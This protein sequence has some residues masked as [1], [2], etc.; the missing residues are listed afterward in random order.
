MDLHSVRA[1]V[2]V[3]REG[4]FTRAARKLDRT[5]PT[6]TAAVKKLESALGVELL[7]RSGRSVKVTRA[8]RLLMDEIGP[9]LEGWDGAEQRFREALTGKEVGLVRLAGDDTAVQH[10]FPGPLRR[11]LKAHPRVEVQLLG[12]PGSEVL[13]AVRTGMVDVAALAG[14]PEADVGLNWRPLVSGERV[15]IAPREHPL[16]RG[17]RPSIRDV[18]KYPLVLPRVGTVTRTVLD[19]TFAREGSIPH[20]TLDGVSWAG[21]KRYV[22]LGLGVGI[23]PAFCLER[24]DRRLVSRPAGH[25]FGRSTYSLVY[26]AR[27]KPSSSVM[28]LLEELKRGGR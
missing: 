24:P 21:M 7:E 14:V 27:R 10:V 22:G 3:A 20:V 8:G 4:G 28:A 12:L 6:L 1:F 18:A 26:S 16:M 11:F 15:L 2:A 9:L 5:Q 23:L 19:S 17:P 25:L 13:D